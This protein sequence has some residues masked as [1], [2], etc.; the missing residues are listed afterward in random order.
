MGKLLE[1]I[2]LLLTI[3]YILSLLQMFRLN[4]KQFLDA[5]VHLSEIIACCSRN[6]TI[7]WSRVILMTIM[8]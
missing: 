3:D 2:N 6:C 1:K 7:S 5:L 8:Q 4:M